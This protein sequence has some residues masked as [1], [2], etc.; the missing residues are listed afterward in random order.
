MPRVPSACNAPGVS[1]RFLC[2][3]VRAKFTGKAARQAIDPGI[4]GGIDR[5]PGI[6]HHI[7]DRGEVDDR[8]AMR[9][10]H[11]GTR[12]LDGDHPLPE[13]LVRLKRF[14]ALIVGGIVDQHGDRAMGRSRTGQ[15][16][17]Q[18]RGIGDVAGQE[19][20]AVLRRRRHLITSGTGGRALAEGNL[21]TMTQ[22][23]LGQCGTNARAAAG[24]ENRLA[25]KVGIDGQGRDRRARSG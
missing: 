10:L 25:A 19:Q 6:S 16:L 20:R 8:P 3:S 14:V 24:D 7:A 22:E 11:P 18:R 4:G 5:I 9:R 13:R 1:H 21:G 23:T 17:F 12:C 15:R 2:L